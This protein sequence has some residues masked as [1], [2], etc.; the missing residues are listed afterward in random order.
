MKKY[1]YSITVLII[2]LL[3]S[4]VNAQSFWN[5]TEYGMTIEQVKSV[6][7]NTVRPLK[8]GHLKDGS[9]ELLRLE[10]VIIVNKNFSA[11]FFFKMGKLTQVMLS[12]ERGHSFHS[13]MLVF[14]S[15]TEALRSKYGPEINRQIQKGI[16]DATW[17]SGRTNIS[18]VAI[19]AGENDA[20]LHINYQVRVSAEADNL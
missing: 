9:E 2:L 10:N 7:P 6:I 20:I 19:S 16:I 3:A 17:L 8:P 14:D 15:L 5:G 18:V 1:V 11:S 13:T 4:I 12:L